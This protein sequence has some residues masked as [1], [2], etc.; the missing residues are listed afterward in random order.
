MRCYSRVLKVCWKDRASREV[1]REKVGRRRT[2]S[3]GSR[4]SWNH[5]AT[6]GGW[7][8]KDSDAKNGRQHRGRQSRRWSDGIGPNKLVGDWNVQDWKMTDW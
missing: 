1:V 7:K 8:T 6:P 4:W 2:W 5:S 3:R